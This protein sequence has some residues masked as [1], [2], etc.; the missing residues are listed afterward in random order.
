MTN[1][2]LQELKARIEK[3]KHDVQYQMNM[4]M[5]QGRNTEAESLKHQEL[6]CQAELR[7]I[8]HIENDYKDDFIIC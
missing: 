7:L 1:T 4:A 6:Q 8:K 5:L 2:E 3:R